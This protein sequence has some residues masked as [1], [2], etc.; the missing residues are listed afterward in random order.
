MT[1][2][3]SIDSFMRW[4]KFSK[5]FGIKPVLGAELYI[6]DKLEK[7]DQ[8]KRE[9]RRHITLL[10]KDKKGFSNLNWLLTFG[11]NHFYY[12]PR[13]SPNELL[14]HCEG[15]IIMSAC[16]SSFIQDEWGMDLLDALVMKKTDV[17]LEIMP[18]DFPEQKNIN[19]LAID[20][21]ANFSIPLIATNDC[22]YV[23]NG[24]ESAHDALICLQTGRK[25]ADKDR[26]R[27][28]INGLYLRDRDEMLGAFDDIRFPK[29]IA[30]NA[31]E[32][33]VEVAEKCSGFALEKMQVQ[34]PDVIEKVVGYKVATDDE[35][36]RILCRDGLRNKGLSNEYRKRAKEE[37]DIIVRQKLSRYFLLVYE[38]MEWCKENDIFIGPGRGSAGGS[39]VCYLLGITAVDPIK[40]NLLFARF[41][42]PERID[43]PD[44]DMDFEDLRRDEI[45][46][47]I[48]DT[49]G[50]E[51][52]AG[53]STFVKMKAK[54]ALRDS[55]RVHNVPIKEVDIASACIVKKGFGDE[56]VELSI[57][58][59]FTEFPDGKKFKKKFPDA[60]EV[61]TKMEGKVRQ[62]SQHAA[63]VLISKDKLTTGERGYLAN[64]KKGKII[65][66]E[67]DDCEFFGLMK[68]DI[69][70]LNALT[71]LH[72]AKKLIKETKGI[73]IDYDGI[74]LDDR[75]VLDEF[76]KG[77][78]IG[79]FQFGSP[80]IRK[81][82]GD[83]QIDTF[84]DLVNANALYRPGTLYA[85]MVD[86]FIN[87]KHGKSEWNHIHPLLE[88]VTGETYGIVVYQEQIMW[89]MVYLAGFS[90]AQ[91]DKVR[92]VVSKSKGGEEFMKFKEE[93]V[94]GCLEKQT[95]DVD[96]ADQLWDS[97]SSFG[98]YSFNKSHAVEYTTIAYWMMWLKI[99]HPIEFICANLT[100]CN[101]MKKEDVVAEAKRMKLDI[102]SP[103][104][105]ISEAKGWI[106]KNNALYCP[107]I[108]IKGIGEVTCSK[109]V[110]LGKKKRDGFYEQTGKKKKTESQYIQIL[111]KIDAYTDVELTDEMADK[112]SPL[113][114]FSFLRDSFL[115]YKNIL[116]RMGKSQKFGTE[117]DFIKISQLKYGKDSVTGDMIDKTGKHHRF[118]IDKNLYNE[119]RDIIDHANENYLLIKQLEDKDKILIKDV[120]SVEQIMA[121]DFKYA[122][123]DL[124]RRTS[125]KCDDYELSKCEECDLRKECKRPV[126]PSKGRYNIMVLGEAPGKSEDKMGQGFI[127]RAGDLLWDSFA[128]VGL[129]REQFHITNI[130]KCWPS[131]TRTPKAKHIKSC[132]HWIEKEI[133]A[134]KPILILAFGNTG[135]SF[136]HGRDSGINEMNG[137][138]EWYEPYKCWVCWCLHPAG[139]LRNPENRSTFDDAIEKFAD[140]ID[141]L[142]GEYQIK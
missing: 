20:C 117:I 90:W 91:A 22:H 2:H 121:C 56:A 38:I 81:L 93:F 50:E 120:W 16:A 18:H 34:L 82:C 71:I 110:E 15:L 101:E 133:D 132:R 123:L 73:E 83:L 10:I 57:E 119:K 70:G 111:E 97:L 88:N 85:G 87:R 137:K 104:V 108:E 75:K 14:E 89:L 49:Y 63:A 13:I 96:S 8:G 32:R 58:Q 113:F 40:H 31:L 136:F 48:R 3:A 129:Y 74:P 114:G 68:L 122:Y 62:R 116:E 66:W 9:K 124:I 27:F 106:I 139:I 100:Y 134:V 29:A 105:G 59:A 131:Q 128:G 86:E 72:G 25:I 47:H 43:L 127:G 45:V 99:Y 36:L 1:D 44:I 77:N 135:L 67:K 5:E 142:S 21:S 6:V 41:I 94:K 33:T 30:I 95:L 37:L 60:V 51:N 24:D 55:S 26:W 7:P 64:G 28:T 102:R 53:V 23:D 92:K 54:G 11:Y 118:A 109:I 141:T 103:K 61:A 76:T 115:S 35:M 4:Q 19:D 46:K 140:T 52:V 126:Y 78:C 112:I 107:F 69:L 42:S 98:F 80:G 84:I 138:V 79:V 39:L 125:F 17:Y 130:C 12:R 65:N